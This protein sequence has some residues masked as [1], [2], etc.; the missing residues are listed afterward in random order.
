MDTETTTTERIPTYLT[1]QETAE[2]LRV[3]EFTVRRRIKSGVLPAKR[4]GRRL[5]IDA[6]DVARHLR[7]LP[8]A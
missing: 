6:D 7:S 5:L 3:S 2:R 4:D 8:E 1:L